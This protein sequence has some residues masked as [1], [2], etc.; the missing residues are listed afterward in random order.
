MIRAADPRDPPLQPGRSPTLLAKFP[1]PL[2][3]TGNRDRGMH[4]EVRSPALL[5]AAAGVDAELHGR[6]GMRPSFCSDPGLPE[7]RQADPTLADFFEWPPG[8]A[9]PPPHAGAD[10]TRRA[11]GVLCRRR[12]RRVSCPASHYRQSP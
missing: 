8:R 6:E 9:A 4:P 3:I 12:A 7:S 2:P 5:Q 10:G 1:P 11:A